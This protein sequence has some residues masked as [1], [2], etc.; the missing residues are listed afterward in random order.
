MP[1]YAERRRSLEADKENMKNA[2]QN[3][4]KVTK[5]QNESPFK[6]NAYIEPKKSFFQ[7]SESEYITL[8]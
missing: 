5:K 2:L 4:R 3:W 6:S 8:L 7:S 1:K